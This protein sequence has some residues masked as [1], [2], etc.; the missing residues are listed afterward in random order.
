MI[1]RKKLAYQQIRLSQLHRTVIRFKPA[2]HYAANG[3]RL[4]CSKETG[5]A[6][7]LPQRV[8]RMESA[9]A[10]PNAIIAAPTSANKVQ[11]AAPDD[12]SHQPPNPTSNSR[13]VPA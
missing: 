8:R 13:N 3:G 11:A 6:G 4:F 12:A 2:R 9:V 7:H 10:T 1:P 5:P